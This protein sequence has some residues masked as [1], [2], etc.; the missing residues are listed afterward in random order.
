MQAQQQNAQ[1]AGQLQ[2]QLG[3]MQL[4]GMGLQE[5]GATARTIMT[6]NP[7]ENAVLNPAAVRGIA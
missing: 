7:Y 2:R 4:A 3:T 1:L 6:T 5:T